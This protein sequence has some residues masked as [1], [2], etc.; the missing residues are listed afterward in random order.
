M[1]HALKATLLIGAL[2]TPLSNV[3]ANG[4]VGLDGTS[5]AV[6]NALDD[7]LNPVGMRLRLGMRIS[8]LMDVELH[9][10]GG[11][12]AETPAFESFGTTYA[13][14]YLK[15]YLPFAQRSS[16]F[17]LAGMSGIGYS[18]EVGGRTFTDT[19]SGFS[20]G[21]GMETQINDRLD[22]SA[23]YMRYSNNGPEFS[24]LS[25]ISF[26]IKYYF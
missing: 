5:I 4:Y 19:Q 22:L 10:G 16:L 20:Y 3:Y 2:L 21:F 25:A 8:E 18:Q 17:A 15:G 11:S 1:S 24:E 6:E 26:G 7:E 9:L 13:G 14:A 23:D 12:D